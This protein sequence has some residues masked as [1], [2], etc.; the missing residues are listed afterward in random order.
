MA[1]QE[2]KCPACGG[3]MEFDPELQKLK[4]P[5][6]DTVISIEE[7]EDL[8]KKDAANSESDEN[9]SDNKA[10]MSDEAADQAGFDSNMSVYICQSCGGE[11]IADKE[12]GATKC[13][14]CGNNVVFKEIFEGGRTPDLVIPFKLNKDE[15]KKMYK[16]FLGKK[17]LIPK[18][19]FDENHI[20]EIKGVYIPYW[21]FDSLSKFNIKYEG[22]KIKTWSDSRYNYTDTSYYDIQR[23]G[24]LGFE[25]VPVDGSEKMPNDLTESIEPFNMNEIKD[26]SSAYLAGFVANKYDVDDTAAEPRAKER[27]TTSTSDIVRGTV[28]GYSS[29]RPVAT[30]IDLNDAKAK[31]ALY[32]VWI[33]NTTWK[34]KH[35][36]FAMNGQTKKF[37]GNLPMDNKR[38]LMYFSMF[39]AI[40]SV[41]AI[42]VELIVRF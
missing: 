7:Y 23:A 17:K 42:I 21:L 11:I 12:T 18:T 29:V 27:M 1:S 30:S 13:P 15:A 8:L 24:T 16:K 4:C 31:Y 38:A 3:T 28:G 35:Y 2:Y 32:P 39:S 22:T 25:N 41:V 37:V 33:L 36:L 9:K 40:F 19:F 34:N 20:D 10:K 26:Y 6:C 14:F 5:F